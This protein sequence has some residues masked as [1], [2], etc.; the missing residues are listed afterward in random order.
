MNKSEKENQIIEQIDDLLNQLKEVR[1]SKDDNKFP[2][3][4]ESITKNI[5]VYRINNNSQVSA[6]ECGPYPINKKMFATEK[7]ALSSLAYAQLTMIYAET[8][9]RFFSDW[10]ADWNDN[11]QEK[12]CP[13]VYENNVI[14]SFSIFGHVPTYYNLKAE[15][16]FPDMDLYNKFLKANNNE[17]LLKAY[18]QID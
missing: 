15:F 1:E 5:T 11:T 4:E 18:F 6:L 12:I 3:W 16:P 2:T 17:E 14:D 10:H 9:K 8:K 13:M 7:Q